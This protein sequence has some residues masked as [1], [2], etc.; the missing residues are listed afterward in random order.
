MIR[1]SENGFIVLTVVM[2]C[3]QIIWSVMIVILRWEQ[4][5]QTAIFYSKNTPTSQQHKSLMSRDNSQLRVTEDRINFVDLP[6]WASIKVKPCS[7]NILSYNIV[8]KK[9]SVGKKTCKNKNL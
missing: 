4:L 6:V 7:V 8:T 5:Q 3:M 1:G 2:V 9:F